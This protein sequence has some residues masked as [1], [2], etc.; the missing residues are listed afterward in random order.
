MITSAVIVS[1]YLGR[2]LGGGSLRREKYNFTLFFLHFCCS[3]LKGVLQ[4]HH[5]EWLM[6]SVEV[7]EEEEEELLDPPGPTHATS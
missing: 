5:D 4:L 1:D 3:E 7:E 2:G 6:N